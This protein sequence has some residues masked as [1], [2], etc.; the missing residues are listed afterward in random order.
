MLDIMPDPRLIAHEWQKHGTCTGLT[1]D[2]YFGVVRKAYYS[3]KIPSALLN[4]SRTTQRSASEIKQLFSIADPSLTADG[5]AISC[6]NRYLA[7]VEFCFSKS[8]QPIA[9][10]AVRDCNQP[11]IRIPAGQ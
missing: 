10:Q 1:A 8:L 3:I 7:G 2:Q 6:H 9:C 11:A 4:P 5:I